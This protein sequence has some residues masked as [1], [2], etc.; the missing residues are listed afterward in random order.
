MTP[1]RLLEILMRLNLSLKG[2]VHEVLSLIVLFFTPRH[3][4]WQANFENTPAYAAQVP[5]P[6]GLQTPNINV[7]PPTD[8]DASQRNFGSKQHSR[9]P[10]RLSNVRI[11][12][13]HESEG[14]TGTVKDEAEARTV[15]VETAV[16]D[17][18]FIQ[19]RL[20]TVLRSGPLPT[21][22]LIKPDL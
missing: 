2:W 20:L 5:L 19:G 22:R 14:D 17:I 12:S 11:E 21:R 3:G 4:R 15:P 7:Q 1:S 18:L 10:S 8:P 9:A 16:R 13:V 6:L